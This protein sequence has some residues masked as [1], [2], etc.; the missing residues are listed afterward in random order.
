MTALVQIPVGVVVKRAE[1][2]QP[3]DRLHVAAGFGAGR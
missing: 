3:V 2:R 1:G